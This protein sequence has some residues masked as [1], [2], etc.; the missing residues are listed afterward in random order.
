M[1]LPSPMAARGSTRRCTVLY[2][3][4]TRA[5]PRRTAAATTLGARVAPLSVG[6]R[7]AWPSNHPAGWLVFIGSTGTEG[8]RPAPSPIVTTPYVARGPQGYH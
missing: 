4:F 6:T 2:P 8:G 1:Y 3:A 7:A 5:A